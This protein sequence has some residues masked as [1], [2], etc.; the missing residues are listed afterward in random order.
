MT[1]KSYTV[2]TVKNRTTYKEAQKMKKVINVN[3]TE[4]DFDVA[5]NMMD[6]ELREQIHD[7]IAPCT[8]QEF[9]SAYEKAHFDKFGEEW[10]LSKE[11]P[12]Y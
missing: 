3:G 6:D 2:I 5:V 10:E 11:N 9:F 7:D 4:I 1:Y 8:Y 12:T